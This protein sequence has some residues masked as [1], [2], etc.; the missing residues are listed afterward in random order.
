M[1]KATPTKSR[2]PFY[3]VL[4]VLAAAG[5]AGIWYSMQNKAKPIVLDESVTANLPPAEGYLYGKPDAPVTIMEFADF[6]CPRCGQFATLE[7]PEIKARLVDAGLAN[8][9][10]FDF[11]LTE[12]HQNTLSAHLA[13]SCAG[14]QGKF[15]E[16]HDAIF[17]NQDRW[18]GQVTGNPRKVIDELAKTVGLDE[19]KYSACMSS[20]ANLPRIQANKKAGVD[21]GASSTP[22]L[23]IG[24]QVFPGGLRFDAVKK[25]VDSLIALQ[26]AAAPAA[27]APAKP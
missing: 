7:G 3:G 12:I 8:F 9:R 2:A 13:A 25:I 5:G 22:T 26:P 4:L 24:S 10:F 27:A 14:D 17:A 21:R 19:A 23:V 6:E 20:Q 16:M 15:W 1:A 18:N 11:P